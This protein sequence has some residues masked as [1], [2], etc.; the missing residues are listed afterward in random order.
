LGF[1]ALLAVPL[2][3]AFILIGV[4]ATGLRDLA[5]ILALGSVGS[6]FV[7]LLLVGLTALP[8]ERAHRAELESRRRIEE[9][10]EHAPTGI[11]VANLEGRYTEVNPAGAQLLGY[12]TDE[13]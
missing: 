12:E 1:T 13:I 7:A 6:A 9:L 2:F 10:L 5:V 4:E 11:F 8:L 3:G